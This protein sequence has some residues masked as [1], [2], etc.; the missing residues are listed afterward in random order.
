MTRTQLT[1]IREPNRKHGIPMFILLA[2]FMLFPVS[3]MAR[4]PSEQV[5][6]EVRS[7]RSWTNLEGNSIEARVV[8][9]SREHEGVRLMRKTD[10]QMFAIPLNTLSDADVNWVIERAAAIGVVTE[11]LRQEFMRMEEERRAAREA[12]ASITVNSRPSSH[13]TGRSP[14]AI[15]AASILGDDQDNNIVNATAIQSDGAILIG[16]VFGGS[17]AAQ[18][19]RP[20][21]KGKRNS[22]GV[23]L[24]LTG[25]GRQILNGAKLGD[26]ISQIAV[27]GR[28]QIYVAAGADGLY[29]LDAST[30]RVIR[31]HDR[32][33]WVH[34]VSVSPG[35]YY[36]A[37]V[38]DNV[39]GRETT[40]GA[41]N[42][43]VFDPRGQQLSRFR[44]H[45]HTLDLA[46]H[47]PSGTVIHTGWRQ[48]RSWQPDGGHTLPVQIA[49]L[50]GVGFNGQTKWT[51]YDWGTTRHEDNFLNRGDNNMAD[52][53]GY[54]I[55]VG[56]D[57]KLYVAY[58]VAGGNHIFRYSP[59]DIVDRVTNRIPSG[60]DHFHSMSNTRSEH[61]TFVGIYEP[62][63]GRFLAG[64]EFTARLSDGRGNAWRIS[65]GEISAAQNGLFTMAAATAAGAP[66]TFKPATSS[67]DYVGGAVLHAMSNDLGKREYGTYFNGGGSRSVT[68]RN[69]TGNRD[70]VIVYSGYIK[71][72][73]DNR[74][75]F[76]QHFPIQA[77]KGS[78]AQSGF[79]LVM[80]GRG[81]QSPNPPP[82]P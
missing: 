82:R 42:I 44:G 78:G 19:A 62:T 28:D 59:F 49:Y 20:V 81:G 23:L 72:P 67:P 17:P 60:P 57:G 2:V 66:V 9:Y 29:V 77:Q 30:Q 53:R 70:P 7:Y 21:G 18:T 48:A 38:P 61:K 6:N 26:F 22:P 75:F 3:L 76:L 43:Y 15:S 1:D 31:H 80:N 5:L 39:S 52:S 25:D 33:G 58:E 55:T 32:L 24:R 4:T 69:I 63:D 14:F 65:S 13:P 36:A 68:A 10:Q 51:G 34:R 79:F 71:H 74:E 56:L 35:G 41:G 50:R 46:I 64:Q 54:R 11:E 12:A 27:D 37:L 47:E 16:G 45:R 40:P 8:E 73:D